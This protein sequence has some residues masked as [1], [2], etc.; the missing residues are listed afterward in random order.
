M[1]PFVQNHAHS[2][3]VENNQENNHRVVPERPLTFTERLAQTTNPQA[4][5]EILR[6]RFRCERLRQEQQE[7]IDSRA[8]GDI[9]AKVVQQSIN[10]GNIERF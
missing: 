9:T 8:L 3:P 7:E 6:R 1:H 5:A 10:G 2:R 4:R